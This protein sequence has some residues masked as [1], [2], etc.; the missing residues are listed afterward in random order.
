MPKD[1]IP[2]IPAIGYSHKEKTSQKADQ[3]LK[4]ISQSEGIFIR[5]SKNYGEKK[6]GPYK[7][8]GYCKEKKRIYEF[9]GK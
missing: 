3:W 8:D 6:L 5:H 4:Y 9:H 2:W 7:V 1:S